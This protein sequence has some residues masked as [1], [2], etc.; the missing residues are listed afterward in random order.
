MLGQ[1]KKI[2]PGTAKI[3]AVVFHPSYEG[4]YEDTLEL[5]FHD[6]SKREQFVITRRVLAVVGSA[7]DYDR[8]KPKAPYTRPKVSPHERVREV[9]RVSRPPTWSHTRWRVSLPEFKIPEDLV[10]AAFGPKP[11]AAIRPFVPRFDLD[12]Y[13]RFWQVVLW[14][15]EE[16]MRHVAYMFFCASHMR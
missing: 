7:E 6:I 4:R 5:T 3:V 8:L 15:E 1:N 11:S 9:V 12:N 14:I 2:K 13:G 10:K 16:K